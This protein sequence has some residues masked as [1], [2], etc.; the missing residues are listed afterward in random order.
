VPGPDYYRWA[1][2]QIRWILLRMCE[3]LDHRLATVSLDG[4]PGAG[5]SEVLPPLYDE[6]LAGACDDPADLAHWTEFHCLVAGLPDEA[7]FLVD[8]L[9]YN[10]LSQ[11]ET[12]HLLGVPQWQ[13]HRRWTDLRLELS[14]SVPWGENLPT[15]PGEPG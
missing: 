1:G 12:A 15:D 9:W 5:E 10:G 13:V 7:R 8:C 14:S 3:Q 2:H 6:A 4:P 11:T